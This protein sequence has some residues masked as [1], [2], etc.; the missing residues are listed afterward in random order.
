MNAESF[1]SPHMAW[2]F[3]AVSILSAVLLGFN[4]RGVVRLV[5]QSRILSVPLRQEQEVDFAESGRV[6]LCLE[7]PLFTRRFARLGYDLAA[8]DGT[9]V[10][11]RPAFFHAKTSGF[12]SVRME[13]RVYD[14]PGP[15]RYHLRIRG[16]ENAT[17]SDS[18]ECIVFMRP[19]LGRA[20]CF[21]IGIVLSAGL[22]IT[23]LV[24]SLL[25]FVPG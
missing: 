15:G 20:V 14:I 6:V 18:R 9:A 5:R 23:G 8:V 10:S 24:F 13:M 19:H 21:V 12:S 16:L 7:G 25:C 4:I 1:F 17:G 11:G 2:L 22:F 3:A